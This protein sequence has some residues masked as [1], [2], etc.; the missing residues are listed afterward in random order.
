MP[1]LSNVHIDAPLT[2]MTVSRIQKADAFIAPSVFPIVASPK[3][4]D[5]YFVFDK[6]DMNRLEM[7]R[8]APG[9]AAPSAGYRVSDDNFYCE[10][11]HVRNP[12]PEEIQAASDKPLD[13]KGRNATQWITTQML[14]QM[15]YLFATTF[16]GPAI[17]TTDWDGVSTSP[18]TNEILQWDQSGSLPIADVAKLKFAIE[19][20]PSSSSRSSRSSGSR[21]ASGLRSPA[22]GHT[23]SCSATPT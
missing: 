15:E 5:K 11:Y 23:G 21:T 1:D 12:T 10:K 16:W 6:G 19:Q 9:R 8:G 20:T 13:L 3:R 7:R 17:Y 14:L 18:S 2:N 4:S 22:P